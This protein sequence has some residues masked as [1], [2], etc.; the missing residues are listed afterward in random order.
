M[1]TTGDQLP[2]QQTTY[3]DENASLRESCNDTPRSSPGWSFHVSLPPVLI[4]FP[5]AERTYVDKFGSFH[6][7]VKRLSKTPCYLCSAQRREQVLDFAVD[8]RRVVYRSG[9]FLTQHVAIVLP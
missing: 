5:R 4:A 9:D 8:F 1:Y 2:H 3:D 6:G 7:S